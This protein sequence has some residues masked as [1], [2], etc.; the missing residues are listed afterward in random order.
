MICRS[1]LELILVLIYFS[2]RKAGVF[3]VIVLSGILFPGILYGT[4]LILEVALMIVIW[5]FLSFLIMVFLGYSVVYSNV[6][7]L[8]KGWYCRRNAQ[9]FPFRICGYKFASLDVLPFVE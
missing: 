6:L 1:I 4:I 3:F 7:L 9:C 8:F 5:V 2:F